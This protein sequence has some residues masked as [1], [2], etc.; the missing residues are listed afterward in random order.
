LLLLG[1]PRVPLDRDVGHGWRPPGTRNTR[2]LSRLR[3]PLDLAAPEAADEVVVHHPGGLHERVA[4]RR[5]HEGEAARLE[6]AAQRVREVGHR[7]HLPR[8][9]PAVLE[10][11][12]VHVAPE[13]GIERA[14][15]ALDLAE[16][17]RVAH[18]RGDLAAVTHDALG[19]QQR[20]EA[21]GAEPGDG[22]G[23]EPGEGAAIGLALGED[24]RPGESRLRALEHEELEEPAVV[25]H[26]DAPLAVVIADHRRRARGP[27]AAAGRQSRA[28]AAHAS[29]AQPT[30]NAAPPN[31]VTAPSQR[32]P[33]PASTWRL[34]EKSP[35]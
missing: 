13:P 22:P 10:R 35:E 17:A 30:R 21:G 28:H 34:P 2:S 29:E 33:V 14:L 5:A 20:A 8:L 32:C 23:V 1:A 31:G 3:E 6:V 12:P 9:P 15:D 4:D 27:R 16:R 18:G 7:R 24:R 19:A 25:V 11:P 26:G